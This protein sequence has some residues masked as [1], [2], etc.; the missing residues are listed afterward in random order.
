M[1]PELSFATGN[2]GLKSATS[3]AIAGGVTVRLL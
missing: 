1:A 3:T 2:T